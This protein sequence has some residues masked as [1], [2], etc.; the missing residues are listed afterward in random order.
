M[1][2]FYRQYGE[3]Q[4]VIIL[5]GLFGI[6]DN[7]VT[8]G[9]RLAE[10]FEVYILDQR[11]HGQSP[12]S[13]T[14]NY[15]ALADDLFE[16]IEDRQLIN[17]VLIGHSMGGKV[18][19]NFAL[20]NPSKVDKLLIVDMGIKQYAARQSHINII[21]AMINVDFDKISSR[22]DVENIIS[23]K[24]DSPRIKQFVMKNLYRI[25]K[26]RFGWR[27]NIQA[28]YDNL[29]VWLAIEYTSNLR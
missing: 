29:Q 20:E 15:Y 7:W 24:I 10:N 11:N 27:L 12:H 22:N 16:F 28:I 26:N 21:E 2:L 9:K 25:G 1:K 6:S 8:I 23:G 17:P 5:H 3:G 19:M 4:P 13:N 14:F 18:A